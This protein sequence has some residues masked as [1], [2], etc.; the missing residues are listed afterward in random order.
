MQWPKNRDEFLDLVDQAMFE[1]DDLC[2]SAEDEGDE[3]AL[4]PYVPVYRQIEGR[5]QA[6]RREVLEQRHSFADGSDLE[7]FTFALKWKAQ[8]PMFGLLDTLNM[9]HRRGVD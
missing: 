5:L 2:A 6:L 1:V 8:L 9:T 3:D 4:S 7:V